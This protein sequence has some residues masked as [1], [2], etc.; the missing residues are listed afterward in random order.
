MCCSQVTLTLCKNICCMENHNTFVHT[1][2]CPTLLS[3]ALYNE[4]HCTFQFHGSLHDILK[5]DNYNMSFNILTFVTSIGPAKP[6]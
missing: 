2:S 5:N 3:N 1:L 6:V 4:K